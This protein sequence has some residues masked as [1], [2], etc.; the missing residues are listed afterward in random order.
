MTL[1]KAE[2][3]KSHVLKSSKIRIFKLRLN[4]FLSNKISLG[5]IYKTFLDIVTHT[6][7]PMCVMIGLDILALNF[8][9]QSSR[10]I[11]LCVPT[12]HMRT[13]HNATSN[14]YISV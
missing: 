11:P 6:D 12:P 9:F 3:C 5:D 10:F 7:I 2:W 1:L 8:N 14:E 13:H 4:Y